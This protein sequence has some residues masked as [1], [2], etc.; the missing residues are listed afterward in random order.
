[1]P[2]IVKSDDDVRCAHRVDVA[3][4]VVECRQRPRPFV[5]HPSG[6]GAGTEREVD[7]P[8][9]GQPMAEEQFATDDEDRVLACARRRGARVARLVSGS[10]S[11]GR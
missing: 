9:E 8:V 5:G 11:E 1:M 10:R 4:V 7:R 3:V 2:R 6:A